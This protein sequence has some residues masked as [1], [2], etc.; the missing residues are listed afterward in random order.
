LDPKFY[1]NQKRNRE[2]QQHGQQEN[3]QDAESSAATT[4]FAQRMWSAIFVANPDTLSQSV[5]MQ[6]TFPGTSEQ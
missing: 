3:Q 6:A 2:R 1:E 5:P 4:S